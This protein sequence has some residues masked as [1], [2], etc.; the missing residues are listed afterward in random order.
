MS[1]SSYWS[2]EVSKML[3]IGASTLRR[4]C[5]QM[6]QKGYEFTKDENGRRRYFEQDLAALR[7]IKESTEQG[8]ITIDEAINTVLKQ[9][10][11]K[12]TPDP[13][14]LIDH[15]KDIAQLAVSVQDEMSDLRKASAEAHADLVE[16]FVR[17]ESKLDQIAAAKEEPQPGFIR[18][19]WRRVF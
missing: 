3:N 9:A 14:M 13:N 11:V 12:F 16:R 8:G 17:L 19:I 5:L 15:Q 18:R 7:S 10:D 2:Q 4:W 6:E 1:K